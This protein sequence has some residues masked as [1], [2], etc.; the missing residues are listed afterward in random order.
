MVQMK[1]QVKLKFRPSTPPSS[2]FISVSAFI[3]ILQSVLFVCYNYNVFA[4]QILHTTASNIHTG[5]LPGRFPWNFQSVFSLH[6]E[7]I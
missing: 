3:H 1:T 5:V 6:S 4:Y 2:N 7:G